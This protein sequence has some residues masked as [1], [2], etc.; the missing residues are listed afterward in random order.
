M[1]TKKHPGRFD[2]H[3]N[4][5]PDEPMFVL[6]GRDP[7]AGALV[8]VW[9]DMREARGED[10]EKVAEARA[11]ADTLDT[12]AKRLDKA[13]IQLGERSDQRWAL[14]FTDGTVLYVYARTE[15]AARKVMVERQIAGDTYRIAGGQSER[16]LRDLGDIIATIKAPLTHAI[17]SAD[18]RKAP[19]S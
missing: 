9:A 14:T 18:N 4:A 16:P 5:K 15:G 12:W 1:G 13:P 19:G 3:A 17:L 6:L 7:M 2:C 10:P 8:R 11:T